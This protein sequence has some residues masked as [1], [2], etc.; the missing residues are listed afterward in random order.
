[1]IEL[2][3][4][5]ERILL[6]ALREQ[7]AADAA[8]HKRGDAQF[9][10][11]AGFELNAS[12][13]QETTYSA[14]ANLVLPRRAAWC[15]VDVVDVEGLLRRVAVIHPDPLKHAAALA[16]ASSW[17]P[18]DD[19]VIGVPALRLAHTTVALVDTRAIAKAAERVPGA[20]R[21]VEWLG[22]GPVL[23]VPLLGEDGLLGAIT[24]V[25]PD[26][27]APFSVEEIAHS[28][29][30][31]ARCAQ[32]LEGA[33]RFETEHAMSVT[34]DISRFEAEAAR[35]V[36]QTENIAKDGA[37]AMISHELRS[38]LGAIANNIEILQ[39]EICGPVTAL[40]RAVLDRMATSHEH[41][42]SLVDQLLDLQRIAVGK[43]HFEIAPVSVTSAVAVAA[44]MAT[45]QFTQAH[46][47]LELRVDETLGA[48]HTD[49]RKFTQIILNLLSNAAKYTPAGGHV[50]LVA[51]RLDG[52]I[53]LRVHDTGIGIAVDHHEEVFEPFV[54]VRD[55]AH[56][57]F[58][59]AGLGLAISR[60][61][62]RGLG[63]DL[64]VESEQG[65][66]STFTLTIP[67][68]RPNAGADGADP[69]A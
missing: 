48:L 37:I 8:E 52:A 25:G 3:H 44:D 55:S 68:T 24:F 22:V 47:Q 46:V 15:V 31:A 11:D 64:T 41:V 33:R 14:I 18:A 9:L 36:A 58:G 17:T 12:L 7:D 38:P 19:D 28:E 62:A 59:G 67:D 60:Q 54:Q 57:H 13:D 5:T 21:V 45:W 39:L 69:Q 23:I 20:I 26:S 1:M 42:M 6:S 34:A 50:L 2:Q 56:R 32:A 10:A 65:V 43:M 4:L 27:N 61:F 29:A 63:G 35:N 30:L 66:G 16:L 51:D 49:S 40:Q 53:R